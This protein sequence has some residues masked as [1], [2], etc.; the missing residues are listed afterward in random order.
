MICIFRKWAFFSHKC[1]H[2]PYCIFYL[3]YSRSYR[4][5]PQPVPGMLY[6]FLNESSSSHYG[7]IS[8]IYQ[9]RL[10]DISFSIC[11]DMFNSWMQIMFCIST[12]AAAEHILKLELMSQRICAL[13]VD[14][15]YL[16]YIPTNN[17][18]GIPVTQ[19]LQ[20]WFEY[21]MTL[22]C[23]QLR[24]WLVALFWEVLESIGHW[25]LA[26]EVGQITRGI[27][28]ATVSCPGLLSPSLSILS[29]MTE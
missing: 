10:M 11:N 6:T 1:L 3:A 9:H 21:T 16:V 12:N 23:A 15:E 8:V 14:K 19:N 27:F 4:D 7:M 17:V 2:I 28:L 29:A 24:F 22:T 18:L 13:T 25:S 26:W 20:L 5:T